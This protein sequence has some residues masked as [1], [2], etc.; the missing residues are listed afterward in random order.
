MK[1][2]IFLTAVLVII[3]TGILSFTISSK[4]DIDNTSFQYT[5]SY[6]KAICRDNN[7]CQDYEIYCKNQDVIRITP[8]T[9]AIIQF[10]EDW[11]DPRTEDIKNKI[12]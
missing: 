6:T 4:T 2:W 8:I 5:H 10:P 9:G 3:L 1:K 11:E 12:C 7:L